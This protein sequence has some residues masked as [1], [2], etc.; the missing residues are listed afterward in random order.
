MSN[1]LRAKI[2]SYL[3]YILYGVILIA[4]F[5]LPLSESVKNI[6]FS[7]SLLLWFVKITINRDINIKV[8]TLGW[9]FIAFLFSSILSA[10]NS[11]YPQRSLHGVWD[12]FRYT[13]FF[14]I[15]LNNLNTENK[16]RVAVWVAIISIGIGDI[17]GIIRYYK[18]YMP[19]NP[20]NFSILS[21][22]D[23]NSTAQYL[24]M[25]LA[26][27][28][29]LILNLS[30]RTP[31][32]IIV[33]FVTILTILSLV[34][35][36]ARGIW[37][38]FLL[39]LIIFGLLRKN[40]K[41]PVILGLIVLISVIGLLTSGTFKEKMLSFKNPLQVEQVKGRYKI[42]EGALRIVK[43]R[44]FLGIGPR[45]FGLEENK[46]RY[47][48]PEDATHGHNILLNVWA[49]MGTLGL[50]SLLLWLSYYIYSITKF[51]SAK[52]PCFA[53]VLWFASIGILITLVIGG[54]THPILGGEGST[55]FMTLTALSISVKDIS[56][57]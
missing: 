6:S 19:E 29:G 46:K 1:E 54:I 36:Y 32:R 9:L 40:W 45:C 26:L 21:L 24:N 14:F 33:I 17:F 41:V 31:Q 23:K 5:S 50:L 8:T 35:T 49:E 20:F 43:D 42:W 13:T 15:V 52:T 2:I 47:D 11:P 3:D 34:L 25:I 44:P 27:L 39:T 38:A 7:L 12:V 22:G 30:M 57:L 10:I 56:R 4:V 37:I 55:I 51:R 18:N 16:I 48:L 53:Q 28:F